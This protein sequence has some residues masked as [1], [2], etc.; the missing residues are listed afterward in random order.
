MIQVKECI[1]AIV[2]NSSM[3]YYVAF[4]FADI[5]NLYTSGR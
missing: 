5:V 3:I 2:T 1:E 4:K